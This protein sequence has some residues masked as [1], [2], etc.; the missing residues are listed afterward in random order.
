MSD[1][2]PTRSQ[3]ASAQTRVDQHNAS[4][5]SPELVSIVTEKVYARL[6][7][8]LH[9]ERERV[10]LIEFELHLLRGE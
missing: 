10:R 2:G 6:Q 3:A 1:S 8:E 5:I 9:I 4:T 7:R